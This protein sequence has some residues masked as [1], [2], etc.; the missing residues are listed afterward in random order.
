M[1]VRG[2]AELAPIA[3]HT[4]HVPAGELLT[5]L[6]APGVQVA[7]GEPEIG[8]VPVL[9][10]DH[11][12]VRLVEP[13]DPQIGRGDHRPT[14]TGA[15]AGG[16]EVQAH[17]VLRPLGQPRHVAAPIAGSEL[18]P[19]QRG[20][21]LPVS[22]VPVPGLATRG[23]LA[24]GGELDLPAVE[25]RLHVALGLRKRRHAF[26][27]GHRTGPGVIGGQRQAH[28][29]IRVVA[30]Q[31]LHLI[32]QRCHVAPIG[33]DRILGIGHVPALPVGGPGIGHELGDALGPGGAAR[34]GFPIGFLLEL[35]SRH[36]H[37]QPRR[38]GG[39]LHER[40]PAVG[41][42]DHTV[43]GVLTGDNRGRGAP[44]SRC[45][46]VRHQREAGNTRH[47]YADSHHPN[48]R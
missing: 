5:F 34:P 21:P 39:L 18:P 7:E 13:G 10:R 22:Q 43:L 31:G 32:A 38:L 20:G 23:G 48:Q 15:D 29:L 1:Q 9:L 25:D 2:H 40:A 16:G 11:A 46:H 6:H 30:G 36:A 4:D 3:L 14:G 33:R 44:T 47:G 28:Q 17:M 12:P 41:N 35:G 8:I 37:R 26:V 45:L 42:V 24:A 27:L 19:G